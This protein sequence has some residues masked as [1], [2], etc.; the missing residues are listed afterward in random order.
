MLETRDLVAGYGPVEM[1]PSMLEEPKIRYV[2]SRAVGRYVD[3]LYDKWFRRILESEGNKDVLLAILRELIP[4][5][6]IAD[7]FYGR[8]GRRKVNPFIDGHD[9]YFD[10][11]CRDADGT[12]FV[13]EMQRSEQVNFRDRV[14]FYSTFPIQ[15]QVEAERKRLRRRR[16]HDRQYGY[17]PVYVVSFL[18]F[19]LH[20]GSDRVLYRYGLREEESGEL[21]TDRITFIFL[22]MGN[23]RRV[24][25]RPEDSFAEK[26]SYAFTR[27]S[28]LSERPPALMEEV[29][30]RLFEACEVSR[31]PEEEQTEYMEDNMTT[32]MDME[33]IL[34]TAELR[35][36]ERGAVQALAATARRMVG[37]LGYTPEQASEAT[38]LPPEQFLES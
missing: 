10:V 36:E 33:N 29:F 7:L 6:R 4:E 30:R 12:R 34:F 5:R 32:R 22:E 3:I 13:V 19:S 8:R 2:S 16:D 27:M 35:G 24:E 21:M 17:A 11:E 1:P 28:T 20:K 37:Q 14:L 38:G 25:I 26:I 18:D 23:F 15:E 31:L 9:A